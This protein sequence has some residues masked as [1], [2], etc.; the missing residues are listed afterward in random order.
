[1]RIGLLLLC[2]FGCS[3]LKLGEGDAD[4][5]PPGDGPMPDGPPD[6]PTVAPG[7]DLVPLGQIA[8]YQFEDILG[9]GVFTD[10]SG[11]AHNAVAVGFSTVIRDVPVTSQAI[12]PGPNA[13]AKVA[14]AAAFSSLNGDFTITAWIHP[15]NPATGTDANEGI[16]DQWALS[17]FEGRL[18][19]W[20]GRTS[21]LFVARAADAD[22]VRR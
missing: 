16:V 5:A 13:S 7:C 19:C 3:F 18:R 12:V 8:C 6:S 22:R 17:I 1:M 15:E 2:G 20:S 10:G 9:N 4:D 11:N 21:G 14:E